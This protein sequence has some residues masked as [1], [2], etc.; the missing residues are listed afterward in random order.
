MESAWSVWPLHVLL[1]GSPSHQV[2]CGQTRL[3]ELASS[4]PTS[5]GSVSSSVLL[6][7]CAATVEFGIQ[8]GMPIQLSS[9]QF[10]QP[11]PRISPSSTSQWLLIAAA[12]SHVAV[13]K[14]QAAQSCDANALAVLLN[15][16]QLAL[17]TAVLPTSLAVW[18]HQTSTQSVP[19]PHRHGRQTAV[20]SSLMGNGACLDRQ[21]VNAPARLSAA[22]RLFARLVGHASQTA[23]LLCWMAC[24][25]ACCMPP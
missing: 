4:S 23:T 10:L 25:M 14:H 18:T 13:G 5:S 22:C 24:C 7:E 2:Q 16:N 12:A 20:P 15:N 1:S 17:F 19:R 3:P 21:R 11:T 6:A 8:V 9:K